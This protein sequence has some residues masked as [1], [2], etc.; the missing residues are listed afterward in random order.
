MAPDGKA[1]AG[2]GGTSTG[3][4]DKNTPPATIA[5]RGLENVGAK[6]SPADS[7]RMCCGCVCRMTFPF[8]ACDCKGGFR[9]AV[10]SDKAREVPMRAG[11][12]SCALM[13]ADVS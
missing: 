10:F 4:A 13:R 6:G 12:H 5:A 11:A 8:A 1:G 7:V 2:A 9:K 3:V